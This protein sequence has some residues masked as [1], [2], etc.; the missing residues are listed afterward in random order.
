MLT[1]PKCIH[2]GYVPARNPVSQSVTPADECLKARSRQ[3]ALDVLTLTAWLALATGCIETLYWLVRQH[4]FGLLVFLHPGYWWLSPLT[5][6]ALF[7]IPG[8]LL[9]A[10][11]WRRP[12]WDVAAF[13]VKAF[14]FF[15][16]LNLL[17]LP[18]AL[19]LWAWLIA[20]LGL[21]AATGRIFQKHPQRC[22]TVMRYSLAPLFLPLF[23]LIVAGPLI[24]FSIQRQRDAAALA[25]LPPPARQAPNVLLIVLDAVRAD[26][27]E[28]YGRDRAVAPHLAS[29]AAQGVTFEQAWSTAPW[30]LPSHGSMFTGR[31]PHEL[32]VDWL[33]PLDDSHPTL[34]AALLARGWLTGG[35]VGNRRY[36]TVET[37]L[38][39]G[40][41]HY[42]CHRLTLAQAGMTTALGRELLLGPLPAQFGIRHRPGRKHADEVSGGFLRWLQRRGDRPFFAFLNFFDAHD[43]YVPPPGFETIPPCSYDEVLFRKN[44]WWISKDNLSSDQVQ[45]LRTTYE[46]CIRGLDAHIGSMLTMVSISAITICFCTATVCTSR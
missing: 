16:W 3:A 9:A 40:F 20:A 17:L 25:A 46:D 21:A 7:I 27:L 22:L 30:T 44:W 10:V 39:R 2:R 31:Q 28:I 5:Q 43:A 35:F 37:G 19:Y 1:T 24:Q 38:A 32:S 42:E 36:C 8:S 33:S 13:A 34:A 29:L 6:L 41:L 26:A 4:V 14:A 11:A 45:R 12:R 23:L 15:G 18:T